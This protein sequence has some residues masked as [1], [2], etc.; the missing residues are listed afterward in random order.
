MIVTV[1]CA[2]A[3]LLVVE[4]L[5]AYFK[6]VNVPGLSVPLQ[7]DNVIGTDRVCF[8][9]T[10]CRAVEPRSL[11]VNA[12]M[13]N[14]RHNKIEFWGAD[15]E[16]CIP[17]ITIGPQGDLGAIVC[18]YWC[19]GEDGT[20]NKGDYYS[21]LHHARRLEIVNNPQAIEDLGFCIDGTYWLD[22][23]W[24]RKE[25]PRGMKVIVQCEVVDMPAVERLKEYFDTVNV[26]TLS[27]ALQVDNEVSEGCAR[28]AF[29][30]CNGVEPRSLM[31]DA[32]VRRGGINFQDAN[33]E[34]R[35]QRICIGENGNLR[36]VL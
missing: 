28:F 2:E 35:I 18:N 29:T 17:R 19:S 22:R 3:D 26:W 20:G 10:G 30:G 15:S 12:N 34:V 7:A 5:R 36:A 32:N 21:L 4:Q 1:W 8:A 24:Q 9:F 16:V 27:T 33:G 6:T 11:M 25:L 13:K 31:V 14:V 23:H